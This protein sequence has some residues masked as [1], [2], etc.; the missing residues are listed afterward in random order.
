MKSDLE[1]K[2]KKSFLVKLRI[3][4]KSK[5]TTEQI[6]LHSEK[7][8]TSPKRDGV[9]TIFRLVLVLEL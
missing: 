8:S 6:F 7:N 4:Q 9:L 5:L 2:F 1:I 3:E